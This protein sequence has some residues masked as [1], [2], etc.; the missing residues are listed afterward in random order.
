MKSL[1][2]SVDVSTRGKRRKAMVIVIGLLE[3]IRFAEEGY[4][5]RMP[6]NLQGSNA[7]DV[8][9]ESVATIIDAIASLS[10]AY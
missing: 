6:I 7:Y 4:M 5:E 8:A 1:I 9:D 2:E 10:D 3:K